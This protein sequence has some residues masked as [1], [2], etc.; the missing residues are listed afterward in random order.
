MLLLFCKP[1]IGLWIK[2]P[3]RLRTVS[4][5]DIIEFGFEAV[6]MYD[7]IWWRVRHAQ[8]DIMYTLLFK[9]KNIQYVIANLQQNR[10]A[11]EQQ[12]REIIILCV[13]FS[14]SA[15]CNCM[16]TLWGHIFNCLCSPNTASMLSVSCNKI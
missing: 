15:V 16:V 14:V 13:E 5:Q 1:I 4:V 6:C 9:L 10:L 2:N 3:E 11:L 12:W 7:V 8:E